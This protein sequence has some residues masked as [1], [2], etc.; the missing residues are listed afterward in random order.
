MKNESIAYED[1]SKEQL[2]QRIEEMEEVMTQME[3]HRDE[4]EL[5]SFPWIGNLGQWHWMVQSNHV[6]FNEKKITNLG[7]ERNEIP[8]NVGFEYFTTILHPDDYERVMENMGLHLKNQSDAYDVEYRI[9]TKTGDYAWYY[10]RG[11]VTKRNEKGEPLVVSGIVFDISENKKM[12]NDLKESNEKL[13]QLAITDELT[14]AYN[15]RFMTYKI[16]DEVERYN[17]SQSPFS[18]IMLDIDKFKL[19][20]DRLGHE[21][22][23]AVLK[24]VVEVI[25]EEIRTIDV[26][27]RWGGDEFLVLLPDT[28]KTGAIIVAEKIKVELN[29]IVI[30]NLGSITASIGVSDYNRDQSIK[31][32]IKK[33]DNLMYKAKAEGR[34]CVRY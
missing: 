29:N 30:E 20:N 4:T 33:V 25:S 21:V 27:S 12:E 3:K 13:Q 5:L 32:F 19:A 31:V 34:N 26:L 15:R 14:S 1:L 2:I 23:D 24:K 22:G 6:T 17:R 28:T 16:S 11:K 8:E 7:Y 18:L 9:L 10:D